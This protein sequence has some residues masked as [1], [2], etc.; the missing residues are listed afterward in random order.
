M[1]WV[2]RFNFFLVGLGIRLG[3]EEF[4][5]TTQPN[6]NQWYLGHL[7]H[8]RHFPT[9]RSTSPPQIFLRHRFFL[10][11]QL[12][13]LLCIDVANMHNV[14]MLMIDM[15]WHMIYQSHDRHY[16]WCLWCCYMLLECGVSVNFVCWTFIPPVLWSYLWGHW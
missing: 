6:P 12:L 4:S 16:D 11:S 1:S 13:P 7:G 15:L 10:S 14:L 8:T 5:S 2:K 9:S 3:V